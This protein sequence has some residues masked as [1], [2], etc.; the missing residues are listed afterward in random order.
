MPQLPLQALGGLLQGEFL[1]PENRAVCEITWRNVVQ[2]A[3]PRW[4]YGMAPKI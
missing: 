4:Q 1:I 3:G 2:V